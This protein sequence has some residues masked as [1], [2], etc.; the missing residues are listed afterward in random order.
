MSSH[1]GFSLEVWFLFTFRFLDPGVLQAW[2]VFVIR[3]FG[4]G[5]TW[6]SGLSEE[7]EWGGVWR[8]RGLEDGGELLMSWVVA[9]VRWGVRRVGARSCGSAVSWEGVSAPFASL[10]R[11]VSIT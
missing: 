3:A 6:R 11:V 8:V 9:G 10:G 2:W 7:G 4:V 5:G 1:W